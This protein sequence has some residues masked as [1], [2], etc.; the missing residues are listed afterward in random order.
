MS[1][2]TCIVFLVSAF[3]KP[4]R[5]LRGGRVLSCGRIWCGFGNPQVQVRFECG[6]LNARGEVLC[7]QAPWK[8]VMSTVSRWTSGPLFKFIARTSVSVPDIVTSN[9]LTDRS[10][11]R[12]P[13]HNIR[14]D[15]HGQLSMPKRKKSIGDC[16]GACVRRSCLP[17]PWS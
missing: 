17:S 6:S 11:P 16:P 12:R 7:D 15:R 9:R 4:P 2:C 3:F 1:R 5:M 14:G 10:H 8:R 13:W